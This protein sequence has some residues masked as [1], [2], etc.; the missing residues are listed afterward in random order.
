M[1]AQHGARVA[2][3]EERPQDRRGAVV[4]ALLDT[5]VSERPQLIEQILTM[6]AKDQ[7]LSK[8]PCRPRAKKQVA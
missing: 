5:M 4:G 8:V 6:V 1:F 3:G 2:H 7:A